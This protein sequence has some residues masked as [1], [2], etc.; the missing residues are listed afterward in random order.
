MR[1]KRIIL[2]FLFLL[3]LGCG[4]LYAKD[5]VILYTGS[6]HAM[7]YPCSCPIERD[8]GLARRATLIR[9]ERKKQPSLLLLDC[10]SFTAGGLLD[11]YTQ[12]VHLD[13]RRSEINLKAMQMMGYDAS[14][15][16]GDEFNFGKDFFL[17]NAVK[18]NPVFL[19]A[20]LESDKVAPYI[21]RQIPGAKI[22]IIGLISPAAA[23]KT[24]GLKIKPPK[25]IEGLVKRLKSEGVGIIVVLSSLDRK[26]NLDLISS[27]AGIDILITGYSFDKEGYE[28][29]IGSTFVAR[30]SWQGRKMGKLTLKIKDGKLIDCKDEAMRLWDKLADDQR[31][32]AVLPACFSDAN[33][34]KEGLNGIC[35]NPGQPGANCL[36][37]EPNRLRLIVINPEDCL[38]C[39]PEPVIERLKKQF[40]GLN[41][42]YVDVKRAQN[43]IKDLSIKTLPAYVISGEID[44]EANFESFRDKLESRKGVYL[45]KP[46]VS[47]IAYFIDRQVKKGTLDL[48]FSLFD[49]DSAE[50]LSTLREFSPSLHFLAVE[51]DDGFETRGGKAE[52]EECLRGVCVQKYYPGRFW[53]YLICRAKNINSSWWDDCLGSPEEAQKIRDCAKAEEGKL[54]LKENIALNKEIEVNLGLSY[55]LDN[56]QIFSSRGVPGKEEIRKI[57]KK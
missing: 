5:A 55:L 32:A 6:T 4:N 51:K 13:M 26:E 44:K 45:L 18:Y 24:E 47:G 36:F 20:N 57:L 15:V 37:V 28:A 7:L 1:N 49:K 42:E 53:D 2:F 12:N 46:E 52:A 27:V 54:L 41:P 56:H 29:K 11:E 43:L 25:S 48:F 23:Q 39:N 9:N 22:G 31:I 30:V 17:K 8:G 14:A 21:V 10:G 16:S 34:R 19:S 3:G 35:Q 50:L 40:P 33:C 38:V